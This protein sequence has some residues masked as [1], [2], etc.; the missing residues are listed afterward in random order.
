MPAYNLFFLFKNKNLIHFPQKAAKSV[1]NPTGPCYFQPPGLYFREKIVKSG[2]G[3]KKAKQK[4]TR[5]G[6]ETNLF[7][8]A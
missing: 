5:A 7:L 1:K 2:S 6:P 3:R 4:Q 8:Q